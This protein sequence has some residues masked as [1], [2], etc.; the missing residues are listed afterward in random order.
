MATLP[1]GYHLRLGSPLDRVILVKFM[2]CTY[3]ELGDTPPPNHLATTVDHYLSCDTPLWVV[4]CPRQ[5][6]SALAVG[7]IWLGQA[8]DQRNG[9]LHPYVLLLYVHPDHRRQ[10]VF[11]ALFEHLK[12]EAQNN[13]HV[14]GLRL[15]VEQDNTRA[16]ATYG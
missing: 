9:L 15:Y 7:C 8:S 1:P 13:P 4:E 2:E 12:S 14:V 16:H 5:R 3:Q 6:G 11:R 10:G